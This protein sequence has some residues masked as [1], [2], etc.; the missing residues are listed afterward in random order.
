MLKRKI[1]KN[2]QI[3]FLAEKRRKN[4]ILCKNRHQELN[5]IKI[6]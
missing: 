6:Q 2:K 1:K 4:V 5:F 3:P